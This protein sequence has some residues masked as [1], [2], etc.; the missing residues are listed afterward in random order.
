MNTAKLLSYRLANQQISRH[1]FT[2]PEALVAEMGCIQAQDFGGAKWAIGSRIKN[3]TDADIEMDFNSGK[4]LRTHIL[5]PTWHFVTPADIGWMLKLTAPRIKTFCKVH[6]KKLGM[7]LTTLKRSKNIISKALTGGK[8]LT[9]NQLLQL[10]KR[11]K[12]RT[13][14]LRPLFFMLD[15]ELDGIICS[16][17]RQG[18]QFTY[19]L[20]EERAPGIRHLDH[21]AAI[22]ELTNRYFTSRGPA[23]LQDFSWWSGLILS[24]AKKGIEMNG[25]NLIYEII[26]G[27][28][29][30]YSSGMLLNLKQAGSVYLLPIF[31]EFIIAYKNRTE[32]LHPSYKKQSGIGIFKP[33]IIINGQIAGIWKRNAQNLKVTVESHPFS[34]LSKNYRHL[35]TTAAKRYARFIGKPLDEISY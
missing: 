12:I 9:R 15:A 20:L 2:S 17:P 5:R 24:D 29:Y 26:N 21:D 32:L 35:I 11:G 4:I 6:H 8:Y 30:W 25:K 14:N 1:S 22:A 27:Q 28:T 16:G 7:D 31:D 10:L 13:D 18:K 23:T 19:A 33:A 34:P 3:I